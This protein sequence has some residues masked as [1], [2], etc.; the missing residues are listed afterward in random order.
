MSASD[1]ESIDSDLR[2][3]NAALQTLVD[4]FPDLQPEVF[5]E[6]LAS[7]GPES[8]VAVVTEQLLR[9]RAKWTRGRYR[10]LAE[11]E[12]QH[13]GTHKY[14]YRSPESTKDT[15]GVPLTKEEKF[16]STSY[17]EAAKEALYGEFKGLSRSTVRA[18]LAEYNWSYTLARPT[19][20]VLSSQSWRTSIT[21]F[22]MRRKAPSADHHPLVMW[23][24]QD[25][26]TG[27]GRQPLLVKT[28]SPELDQELYDTLIMPEMEKQRKE[29]E[30]QDFEL[31]LEWNENEAETAGEMY[32]CEC[33][34]IP[35][36]L[37]QMSTCDVEGH[38]LCFQ[39]IRHAINAALYDQGW[40]RNINA[41][42]CTIK[43]IAPITDGIEDCRGCVPLS[44][45]K[46]A[47]LEE[48]DGR[49]AYKKLD[50][51]FSNEAMLKSQLPLIRCP[52]CPYTEVDD[53]ALPSTNL[54]FNLRFRRKPLLFASVSWLQVVCFQA[55]R[56]LVFLVVFLMTF[57]ISIN[58]VLSKPLPPF[59]P[60][61]RALRRVH[62]KRRGL[63]FQCLSPACGRSSCLSCSAPWHDPHTCYSSQLTSLRL[64]LERATTDAIK[65][66]CPK[67]AM[68][69]VKSGGCNKLVC[70]CGYSMCYVCREGLAG[71][72]YQHFCQHFRAIPGSKCEE[73]DKCDLYRVE[74]EEIV[75]EKAKERAEAEWW[76]RQGKGSQEGLKER[77]GR[78]RVG[79]QSRR[80]RLLRRREVTGWIEDLVEGVVV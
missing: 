25:G 13:A 29:Q 12:K 64:A 40:T 9:N 24:A 80:W 8:R 15:R 5:R 74:D 11:Q 47:L 39:C 18:V 38:Y 42:R 46:R 57:V 22:F 35:S 50:E 4:I 14:K 32:E 31:A 63:R 69:F 37:Q 71:V 30:R 48:P 54:L 72:G 55:L 67:C 70:T 3:L 59:L 20:L 33:C 43:C 56:I 51:R 45:V 17:K 53:L 44:F 2:D 76:E 41:D 62:L 28:K 10:M 73:C 36:T 49:D 1:P 6:M 68:S 75:I 16:R 60:V 78:Q 34:F 66:T 19:L 7:L 23:L 65:R 61:Q 79:S 27:R 58:S 52:F 26:K 77:A 21:N